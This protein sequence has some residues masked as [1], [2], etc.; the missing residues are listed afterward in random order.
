[1]PWP[2]R[3][4]S[5]GNPSPSPPAAASY[6]AGPCWGLAVVSTSQQ[7]SSA[8]Q[9]VLYAACASAHSCNCTPESELPSTL[10][11]S[12]QA[13]SSAMLQVAVWPCTQQRSCTQQSGPGQIHQ[14]YT[15]PAKYDHRQWHACATSTPL[16]TSRSDQSIATHFPGGEGEGLPSRAY[17]DAALLHARQAA[18]ADVLAAAEDEVL[19]HLIA[20]CIGVMLDTPAAGRAKLTSEAWVHLQQSGAHH[21]PHDGLAA[22]RLQPAI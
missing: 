11:G 5:A 12:I 4:P 9:H 13:D 6:A 10:R 7:T 20:H 2:P 14:K 17:P 15:T 8:T 3:P 16:H 21:T 1:M 18:Q 22:G 19:I